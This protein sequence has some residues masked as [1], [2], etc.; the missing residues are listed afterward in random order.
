L[1]IVGTTTPGATGGKIGLIGL[2][3]GQYDGTPDPS[4]RLTSYGR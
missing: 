4:P 2:N 3:A 1:Y